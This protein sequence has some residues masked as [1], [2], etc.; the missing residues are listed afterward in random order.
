MASSYFFTNIE[1]SVKNNKFIETIK[2][3]ADANKKQLYLINVPLGGES[4]YTYDIND[5]YIALTPKCKLLFINDG[6]SKEEFEDY[7]DD[8]I[9]DVG[10][11]SDKFRYKEIIG[12]PK[13][14][15]DE[16]VIS[17]SRIQCENNFEL[18][19]EQ[20]KLVDPYLQKKCEL[21][22][23][24]LTGSIND[25]EKVRLEMPENILDKIKQKI[26][27]FDGEQTRFIY[28]NSSKKIIRIQGLSGTGKTELLLHKIKDI[29][30]QNDSDKI[31][32]TCH[33]RILSNELRSR[34]PN[35][36]NFMKVEKQILWNERMFCMHSWGGASEQGAYRYIC[37]FYNIP[38]FG[39]SY[40]N[41]F[42][43]VCKNACNQIKQIQI[44]KG[45]NYE[46]AFDY[47]FIDESQDFGPEFIELCSLVTKK[48]I[49][50]A[51]DIFQ[52]IFDSI[53]VSNSI[54]T[55]HL[56]SK[57]YRTDP[58][59]LMF[60]HGLGMGLFEDE[61]LRWLEDDQWEKCGYQFAKNG[62]E[63]EF[64][65]EPLRRFED[66]QTSDY[67][68]IK[69]M[70]QISGENAVENQ[71]F[72]TINNIKLEHPSV[73]PSDIG[74]I[75]ID[76]TQDTY[77]IA[78]R[79]EYQIPRIYGWNVN[80]AYESKRCI[81]DTVLVSNRNNVKGLEFPFV[82][83]VTSEIKN[84]YSYRNALYT[85]LTRSFLQST[86]LIT[87]VLSEKLLGQLNSALSEIYTTGH[88]KVQEPSEEEKKKILTN[89][90][91]SD[92]G[93]SLYEI[94]T[95]KCQQLNISMD[96][97]KKLFEAFNKFSEDV[98][99]RDDI[100]NWIEVNYNFIT[101]KSK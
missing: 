38:Y 58:R 88:M 33:N 9:E 1:Q 44:E 50:V 2:R 49:Y 42:D 4:K 77:K 83:C 98:V 12:R 15:K 8:V 71:I 90:Q 100:H 80:K 60:A 94:F 82:I 92:I 65:R 95:E 86:L 24:L 23:S 59:T 22:I 63:Y 32:F 85:M 29:Y 54:N 43:V 96:G 17:V 45:I 91:N 69:V 68:S 18:T 66:L 34:L 67:K 73:M 61:K 51:G 6:N 27:L 75:L 78:D 79:L 74:I 40:T 76:G 14:W 97:Q 81:K 3:Y 99:D 87:S 37:Q 48:K 16:L 62:S 46:F 53:N 5:V 101:R 41:T 30:V 57:C 25:P 72:N 7:I 19:L 36:F 39:F 13:K 93:K 52:S 35:Y 64:R 70:H 47:T 84:S 89:I 10:V 20:A 28:E 11:I 55:D 26:V 56:L 21:I 31:L